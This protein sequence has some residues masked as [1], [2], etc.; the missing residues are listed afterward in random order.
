MHTYAMVMHLK[1]LHL[2]TAIACQLVQAYPRQT[3][4][5]ACVRYIARPVLYTRQGP[6]YV[7]DDIPCAFT[8]TVHWVG[9]GC[10]MD[11]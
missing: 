4:L 6:K 9:R 11:N 5:M 1:F 7:D 8:T 2:V 10:V 3:S